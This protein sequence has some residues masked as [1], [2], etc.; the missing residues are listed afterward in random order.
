LS[1]S[2]PKNV[3]NSNPASFIRPYN[4]PGDFQIQKQFTNGKFGSKTTAL[5]LSNKEGKTQID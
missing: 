4:H 5:A 3:S 1:Q 2:I